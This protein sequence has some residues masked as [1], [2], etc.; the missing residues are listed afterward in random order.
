MLTRFQVVTSNDLAPQRRDLTRLSPWLPGHEQL[1]DSI[2]ATPFVLAQDY[3]DDYDSGLKSLETRQADNSVA[4]DSKS[5]S[6][7]KV[8]GQT[9]T[10]NS[11]PPTCGGRDDMEDMSGDF[12]QQRRAFSVR[13]TSSG[14]GSSPAGTLGKRAPTDNCATLPR[15]YCKSL[16]R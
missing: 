2:F 3:R 7:W 6:T 9:F 11:K 13:D 12:P 14:N 10:C 5:G 4:D 16:L 15:L 8:G 1:P